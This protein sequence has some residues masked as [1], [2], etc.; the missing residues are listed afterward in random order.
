MFAIYCTL[1]WKENIRP[2]VVDKL[3][4][5][6]VLQLLASSDKESKL[7]ALKLLINFAVEGHIRKWM[8][9]HS[10]EMAVLQAT[11]KI[12][13]PDIQAQVCLNVYVPHTV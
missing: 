6:P 1:T 4:M 9:E 10:S 13:D 5:K 12:S 3:G 2:L 7:V 8:T 11:E